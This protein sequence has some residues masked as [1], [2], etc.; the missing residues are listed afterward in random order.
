MAAEVNST[1]VELLVRGVIVNRGLPFTL[2]SVTGTAAGW[3][4]MVR[5]D[6]GAVVRL[7]LVGGRPI[8]MRAAIQDALEG[9]L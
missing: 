5:S 2:M 1:E 9:E 7:K 8:A 6:T 4:I 3:N